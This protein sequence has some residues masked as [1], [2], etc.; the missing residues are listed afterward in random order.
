MFGFCDKERF[1]DPPYEA[2]GCWQSQDTPPLPYLSG[3][4][5]QNKGVI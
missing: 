1:S 5:S 3:D 2:L 4:A